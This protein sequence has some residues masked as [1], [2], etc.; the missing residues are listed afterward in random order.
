M[1]IGR[2]VDRC[3]INLKFVSNFKRIYNKDLD[4]LGWNC[5]H[6]LLR[7]VHCY[8]HEDVRVA[9][10]FKQCIDGFFAQ[11]E[12]LLVVPPTFYKNH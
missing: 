12:L 11:A 6:F 5:L 8:V 9:K 3:D 2:S 10:M 4:L 1:I 7:I